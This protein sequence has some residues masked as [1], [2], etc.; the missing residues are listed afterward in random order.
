MYSQIFI[1]QIN[2]VL[3]TQL[4]IKTLEASSSGRS[5]LKNAK[6]K[7]HNKKILYN[8]TV[9]EFKNIFGQAVHDADNNAIYTI[10]KTT[11]KTVPPE[12]HTQFSLP[13]YQ[14]D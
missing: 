14:S 6:I 2:S 1:R 12:K 9:S 7:C 13:G 10:S 5:L 11:D 3:R 4:A 8:K